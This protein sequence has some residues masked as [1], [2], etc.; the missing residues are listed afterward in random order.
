MVCSAYRCQPGESL[1]GLQALFIGIDGRAVVRF[2]C[3]EVAA[4]L[5]KK[6]PVKH[7]APLGSFEHFCG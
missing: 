4:Q 5:V 6:A 3:V 2:G 7:D 1:A